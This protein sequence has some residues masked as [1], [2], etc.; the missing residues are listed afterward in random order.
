MTPAQ[1]KIKAWRR[2]AILF[3]KECLGLTLDEWQ[4]DA[5]LP[6]GGDAN[7]RRRVCMK[8]CTGPGKSFVL[9]IAGWHRLVCFADKGE[10]PK[11]AAISGEGKDNLKDNL[12]AEL[13]KVQQRSEFLKSAFTWTKERIYANDHPETWFLSARSYAKDADSEAIG[14]SLSGLHSRYP[15][16]LLDEIGDMPTAVG[17]K[18][19]QIFT[20]GVADGLIM[21]AGNPTSH[22]GLLYQI[23]TLGADQWVM[24]TITADPD[25]VKRTPRVD[26][27]HAKE[28]IELYGKD[29][30][31][32]MATILG[33]FPPSAIN[34]LLSPDEVERAIGRH[35]KSD[36]YSFSQKRLGI[37]CARFGNDRTVI[38]PRQGLVAFNPVVLRN[39]RQ[40]DIAARAI[41]A[42]LKWGAEMEFVDGTGGYGAGVID[43]MIQGG[44]SPQEI[45]FSGK[46]TDPRYFN[47]RSEIHFLFAEWIKRGGALPKIPGLTR[48]L[49]A[50]TYTFQ[51][52]KLRVEEKEQIKKRLGF[53]PDIA[54]AYALTFSLPDMPAA[55][56]LDQYSNEPKHKFDYDPLNPDL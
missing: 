1:A 23:A 46:A 6:L 37:D 38:A 31:W 50:P 43:F 24:I 36:A 12:W 16:I 21:A 40:N 47:K 39:A 41:H 8:A 44:Y 45:N 33:L 34:S 17:Q 2:D 32:V 7:P 28:Q 13:S 10:H 29:N 15:F 14:R 26:I 54:D 4:R 27:S 5:L 53:S 30:P 48:E 49:T 9:A 52:G 22:A 20:G 55:D 3:A 18:A 19:T 35:Y 11:G 56:P 51:N 42:K 25:D